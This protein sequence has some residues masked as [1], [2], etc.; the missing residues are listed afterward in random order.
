MKAVAPIVLAL[1]AG[2]T[3]Q[4]AQAGRADTHR[5]HSGVWFTDRHAPMYDIDDRRYRNKRFKKQGVLRLDV[6][7]HVRG[8]QRVK[9]RRLLN[10]YY[11]IDLNDFRLR[12]VVINHHGRRHASASLRTGPVST[13]Q[14]FLNHGRTH[15]FAPANQGRWVLNFHNA[16]VNNI[17]V[18]LEPR[19]RYVA[20]PHFD[21]RF[22]HRGH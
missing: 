20:H 9:L 18:V 12:K 2:L 4:T 21:R 17:R 11:D 7:V 1:V 8:S 22:H 13:P 10:R 19:Y 16:R 3:M 15:I 14:R 6:P 5:F